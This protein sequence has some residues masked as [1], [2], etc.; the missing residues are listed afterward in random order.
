M[1]CRA[2]SV[3][4]FRFIVASFDFPWLPTGAAAA[5]G[6]LSHSSFFFGSVGALPSDTEEAS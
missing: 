3:S 6:Q 5:L 2:F 1:A 4:L